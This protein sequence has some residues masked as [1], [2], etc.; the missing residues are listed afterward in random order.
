MGMVVLL[1]LIASALILV[2]TLARLHD[3]GYSPWWTL[4]MFVPIANGVVWLW[5]CLTPSAEAREPMEARAV[6]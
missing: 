3:S 2:L 5:L 4:L 1:V 6:P